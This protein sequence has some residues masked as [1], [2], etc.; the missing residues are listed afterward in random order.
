MQK[1]KRTMHGAPQKLKRTMHAKPQKFRH[2]AHFVPVV[3]NA[4]FDQ[5]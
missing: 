2:T 3:N 5:T 4:F 1:L